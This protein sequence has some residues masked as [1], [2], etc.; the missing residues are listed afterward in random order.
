M[1]LTG[2]KKPYIKPRVIKVTLDQS[3]TLMMKSEVMPPMP[4]SGGSKGA[5][6]P[7]SSPFD[8]KPFS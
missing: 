8:D 1:Q 2:I 6:T 3:I 5:D 4:R 7:F